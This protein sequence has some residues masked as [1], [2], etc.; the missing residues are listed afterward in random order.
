MSSVA[1]LGATSW[2]CTLAAVL[3]E[4]GP[5][6]LVCRTEEEARSV[7]ADGLARLPDL[8]LPASVRPTAQ[9][10][11][12]PQ[13]TVVAV[14]SQALRV[15]L[16]ECADWI[17]GPPL[18]LACKGIEASTGLRMSQV[19]RAVL[20]DA[21]IGV[22]SGPNIAREIAQ[23]LPATSVAAFQDEVVARQVQ[24]R[25]MTGR[26][27]VYTNTD[28]AGVEL[29][30]ALKNVVALGAG[31]GDGLQ[32]GDNAKAAFMTRGLAEIARL[33][34]ALGADPL[35]FQGLAG[36]GDMI[37]TCSSPHSRNRRMGQ[38]LASGLSLDEATAEIGEAVEGVPT[39]QAVIGL[40][41][42][43]G[44]EMPIAEM[45]G[46]VLFEGLP[47]IDAVGEL[48]GRRPAPEF[49]LR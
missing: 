3:G 1:V 17:A 12:S 2:G 32:Y 40:S 37:V 35:T 11:E 14:P 7:Q 31:M 30:G 18:L 41:R 39:C 44:V 20:P 22:V 46:R 47:P 36:L 45:V 21:V 4:N 33:G 9:T 26:F 8:K 5:V 48:M 19:A 15:S 24:A 29:G 28:V 42:S 23:G 43:L 49:R 16:Q 10:P 34:V 6:D 27:R 38:L 13:F 25:F